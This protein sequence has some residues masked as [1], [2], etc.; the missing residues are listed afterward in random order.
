[1]NNPDPLRMTAADLQ[2]PYLEAETLRQIALMRP[3]LRGVILQHPNCHAELA[4]YIG[5]LNGSPTST[6]PYLQPYQD[7]PSW[8]NQHGQ[9][10]SGY[11]MQSPLAPSDEKIWGVLMHIGAIFF[12]FIPPL[13]VWL[14]YRDRSATLDQQGRVALNWQISS[15][16]YVIISTILTFVIIGVIFLPV[17]TLLNL[18]FCV[19][20]AVKAGDLQAWKYPLSLPFFQVNIATPRT[21]GYQY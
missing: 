14:I 9:S 8:H 2:N 13:I 18:V 12:G 10:G 15:L 11:A 19:I 6:P 1:M 7:Q 5:E 4:R 16:I 3:D 21:Y 17:I 20:A